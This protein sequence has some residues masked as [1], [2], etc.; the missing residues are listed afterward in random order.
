MRKDQEQNIATFHF[1]TTFSLVFKMVYRIIY[2]LRNT[3]RKKKVE[4]LRRMSYIC[5]KGLN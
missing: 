1:E 3:D 2:K 5:K 4:L